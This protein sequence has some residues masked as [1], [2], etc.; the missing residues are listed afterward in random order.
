M[1]SRGGLA[2]YSVYGKIF[3]GGHSGNGNVLFIGLGS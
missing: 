3:V 1:K 2:Y